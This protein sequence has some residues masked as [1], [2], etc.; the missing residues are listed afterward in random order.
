METGS[1][2][3]IE[4]RGVSQRFGAIRALDRVSLAVEA[5]EIH[6][7]AGENG[8]GKSTLIRIL[9]GAITDYEGELLVGGR[10]QRFDSPADARTAGI[11]TIHQELSLVE[12][13]SVAD[14]LALGSRGS[15]LDPY[16]P[17]RARVRAQEQLAVVGLEVDPR[18]LVGELP[19]GERQLVEVARAL[20]EQA[21]VLIMDEPTSALSEPEVRLLFSRT[22]RLR[23]QGTAIVFISH[24]LEEIYAIADRITVLRDGAVVARGRAEEL[25]RRELIAAMVGRELGE[26][27]ALREAPS[28]EVLLAVRD[29]RAWDPSGERVRGVSFTLRRGE[30]LGLTGLRGSGAPEVLGALV[31]VEAATGA[32]ELAGRPYRPA[33]PRGAI[34]VGMVLV[35]NDRRLSVFPELSVADNLTLSSLERWSRWGW[36]DHGRAAEATTRLVA[37]LGVVTASAGSAARTLSGGNQQKVALGRCL[38]CE[39]RVL[40]LD[41]PTRG[42]DVGAKT[43]VHALI[44]QAV[45]EGLGAVVVSSELDEL[46]ELS[47]RVLVLSEGR[48]AVEL[49]RREY[50]RE[51]VLAAAM[52]DGRR[53]A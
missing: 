31:G 10:A 45:E 16:L 41:E 43:Q 28:T 11:A 7:L 8:A 4:L 39:P 53:C 30:I 9:S 35:G 37:R 13:L 1:P 26:P 18:R 27:T 3:R 42:I 32:I 50:S 34:M 14:N 17:E 29:L 6:V 21:S 48:V 25:G 23:D 38:L 24:R 51:R 40:L 15:P 22:K 33:D 47:D 46:F 52:G 20:G 2:P 5:G 12:S 44:R 36:L 49:E 19:L